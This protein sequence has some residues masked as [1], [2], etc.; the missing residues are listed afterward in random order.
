MQNSPRQLAERGYQVFESL[1]VAGHLEYPVV[2][3]TKD[4]SAIEEWISE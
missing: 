2:K 3:Q 1:E 4:I